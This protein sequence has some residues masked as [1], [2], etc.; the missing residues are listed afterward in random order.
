VVVKVLNIL[1]RK[2]VERDGTV[3]IPI[4]YMTVYSLV[5]Q[6]SVLEQ[7]KTQKATNCYLPALGSFR[8]FIFH[9]LLLLR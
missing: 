2:H 6:G 9:M 7:V 5:C 1:G 3:F 8:L 4:T